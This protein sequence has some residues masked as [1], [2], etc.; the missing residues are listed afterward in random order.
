MAIAV[1]GREEARSM[2]TPTDL[3]SPAKLQYWATDLSMTSS[4]TDW[5]GARG[6]GTLREAV[7]FAI[8]EEPEGGK[9]P[10]ILAASGFILTP[11]MLPGLWE[12]LREP[13]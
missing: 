13:S 11:E 5:D 3:D 7:Q 8:E 1:C 2:L 10:Y 9:Q 6:F 4:A 12:T